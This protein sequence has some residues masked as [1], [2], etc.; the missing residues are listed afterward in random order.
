MI[1]RTK[2]NFNV[3]DPVEHILD[4]KN[5][6][7]FQYISILD[8]LQVLLNQQD[9]LDKISQ[10][11]KTQENEEDGV[12]RSFRDGLNFKQNSFLSDQE[13]RLFVGLYVDDFEL[14]NP[15]GTSR[16]KHKLCAVYL[17]LSNLP[18]YQFIVVLY[19]F[20]PTMQN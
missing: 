11:Q 10:N 7:T 3:V 6:K 18:T 9:I 13:L 12:Y 16:K 8:S 20:G 2:T 15:L 1:S 4:A 5:K 19:M 17:V 14:C